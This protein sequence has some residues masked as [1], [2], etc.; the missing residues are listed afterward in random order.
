[1]SDIT[2][3]SDP[4]KIKESNI[5]ALEG[6]VSTDIGGKAQLPQLEKMILTFLTNTCNLLVYHGNCV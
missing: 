1:M 2:A 6:D 4:D 3:K 5:F